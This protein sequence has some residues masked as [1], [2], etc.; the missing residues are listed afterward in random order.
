MIM[1]TKT[2][3]SDS[4]IKKPSANSALSV[5][6]GYRRFEV[7]GR[8]KVSGCWYEIDSV[9]NED[10]QW[11]MWVATGDTHSFCNESF[12]EA[13][14]PP[15]A[16]E[17]DFLRLYEWAIEAAQYIEEWSLEESI[18]LTHQM[19]GCRAILEMC[20]VD[21]HTEDRRSEP[22]TSNNPKH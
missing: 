2:K 3:N 17:D 21:F 10:G 16:I 11:D 8:I 22:V 9:D 7:G 18:D 4:D 5:S 13:Y 1:D 14:I 20:P 19:S 6:T 15:K 12:V